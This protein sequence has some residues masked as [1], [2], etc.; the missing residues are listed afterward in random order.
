[1]S[2]PKEYTISDKTEL[3]IGEGSFTAQEK[4]ALQSVGVLSVKSYSSSGGVNKAYIDIEALARMAFEHDLLRSVASRV[5]IDILEAFRRSDENTLTTSEIA[6]MTERPKSSI[7]RAL[8]QLVEKNKLTKVQ[9]G[10]YRHP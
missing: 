6:N 8:S 4:N 3:E 7:S 9:A 2:Q 10:V 5:E 1:M